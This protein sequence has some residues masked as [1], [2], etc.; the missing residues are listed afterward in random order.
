[1]KKIL[2]VLLTFGFI[3]LGFS[4]KKERESE[5]ST[6]QKTELA[7]KKMTLHLDLTESQQQKIRPLLSEKI[8]DREAFKKERKENKDKK[9]S[10]E[11]RFERKMAHLDKQIAFKTDMRAILDDKQY[12][13][14][15][16]HV[17]RKAH[18]RKKKLEK[19]MRAHKRA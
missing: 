6:T 17:A 13:K 12:E 8:L 10:T 19:K 16:K 2:S 11:E 15:E 3:A 1:M 9:L 5:F 4:Q 7:L 14:F 18:K